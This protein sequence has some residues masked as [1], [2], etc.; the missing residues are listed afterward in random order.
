[1][2]L[3][4]NQAWFRHLFTLLFL[5]FTWGVSHAVASDPVSKNEVFYAQLP[6]GKMALHTYGKWSWSDSCH[7][8]KVPCYL[9]A[10]Q[11][12][13]NSS[14]IGTAYLVAAP[15][16][17]TNAPSQHKT[18]CQEVYDLQF[19]LSQ[20][21]PEE[22]KPRAFRLKKSSQGQAYCSWSQ[23]NT[24]TYFWQ[25]KGA[26]VSISFS[27]LKNEGTFLSEVEKLASEVTFDEK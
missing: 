27:S 16:K 21:A 26:M 8:L 5:V 13:K 7:S 25:A 17:K 19:K 12:P 10:L 2:N 9:G 18:M 22:A 15:L 14:Q 23:G 3:T 4:S 11:G 1:M 20:T 6:S 24:L